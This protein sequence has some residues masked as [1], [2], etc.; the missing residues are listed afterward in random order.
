[1]MDSVVLTALVDRWRPETHMFHLSSGETTVMLQDITMIIGLP[2]DS[3]AIS[4]TVSPDR[5]RDFVGALI[6]HRPPDVPAYQNDKKTM[7]VHSRWLTT[8]LLRT[9]SFR[10]MLGPVFGI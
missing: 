7:D 2:I 9:P 4:G 10:G 3:T 8:Y 5:W 6:G 1:M